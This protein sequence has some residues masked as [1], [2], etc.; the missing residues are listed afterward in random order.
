MFLEDY[1]YCGLEIVRFAEQQ[2]SFSAGRSVFTMVQTGIMAALH[3]GRYSPY[4]SHMERI[5]RLDCRQADCMSKP[6]TV[7]T[8]RFR[9]TE[10]NFV[11]FM[12]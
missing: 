10:A 5:P 12:V 11:L 6:P 2:T 9:V 4:Y 1:I 8:A 7:P 3:R